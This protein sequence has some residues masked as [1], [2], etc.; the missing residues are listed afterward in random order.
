MSGANKNEGER[1]RQKMKEE[2][3]A[4]RELSRRAVAATD[5]KKKN[6]EERNEPIQQKEA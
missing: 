3:K 5:E 2:R 4:G 1:D 6:Q